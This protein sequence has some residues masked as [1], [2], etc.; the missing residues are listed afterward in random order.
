MV[1]NRRVE[2]GLC[3]AISRN[4]GYTS[5]ATGL[6]VGVPAW[7]ASRWICVCG[8]VSRMQSDPGVIGVY[9]HAGSA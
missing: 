3:V 1:R 5:L 7:V 4:M 6:P 2:L 9:P 8:W